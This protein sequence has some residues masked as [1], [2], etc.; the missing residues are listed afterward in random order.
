MTRRPPTPE[1]LIKSGSKSLV[2]SKSAEKIEEDIQ[3]HELRPL[4]MPRGRFNLSNQKVIGYGNYQDG[5]ASY[6]AIVRDEN[7]IKREPS[8]PLNLQ[9]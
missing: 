7:S 6:L 3:H 5:E 1:K 2:N 9:P 4:P 8:Q